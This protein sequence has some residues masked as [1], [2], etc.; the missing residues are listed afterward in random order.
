[1]QCDYC[2]NLTVTIEHFELNEIEIAK[3]PVFFIWIEIRLVHK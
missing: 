2:S 3:Y 1:M